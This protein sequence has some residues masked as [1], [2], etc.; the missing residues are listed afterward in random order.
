MAKPSWTAL[1]TAFTLTSLYLLPFSF[2]FIFMA[3]QITRSQCKP[4]QYTP[5]PGSSCLMPCG[6]CSH[7]LMAS[8]L[9]GP[10]HPVSLGSSMGS[11]N[12]PA[13]ALQA[14]GL[15]TGHS[16]SKNQAPVLESHWAFLGT[17]SDLWVWTVCRAHVCICVCVCCL[18][19]L[20]ARFLKACSKCQQL[21]S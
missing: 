18:V 19:C 20:L 16:P 3:T 13:Q 12:P 5:A 2:F 7:M 10:T 1:A 11:A 21:S 8:C 6:L 9:Q 4:P 14:P 15:D 17:K